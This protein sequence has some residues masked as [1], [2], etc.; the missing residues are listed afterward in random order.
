MCPKPFK[1]FECLPPNQIESQSVGLL[2]D[3]PQ[4]TTKRKGPVAKVAFRIGSIDSP[5]LSKPFL[6]VINIQNALFLQSMEMLEKKMSL[7][8]GGTQKKH[9][10]KS[11]L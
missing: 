7:K 3:M 5:V 11:L 9:T 8:N 2:L 10:T 6:S 1:D 4:K